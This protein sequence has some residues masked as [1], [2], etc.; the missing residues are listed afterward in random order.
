M[1]KNLSAQNL[2]S[3]C[4]LSRNVKIKIYR[5]IFLPV[6]MCVHE[7][8]CLMFWEECRLRMFENRLLK[9]IFGPRREAVTRD[10]GTPR[11]VLLGLSNQGG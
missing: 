8:G 7:T 2:L 3:S 10:W 6:G 9:K 1:K 5:T 4:V 11:Q